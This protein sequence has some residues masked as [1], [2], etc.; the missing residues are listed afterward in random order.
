[1]T[2]G[3]RFLQNGA[4][5][6]CLLLSAA[7]YLLWGC[8]PTPQPPGQPHSGYGSPETYISDSYSAESVGDESDGSLAWYYIP[9]VLK[10]T[11]SAPVVIFLHGHTATDPGTYRGHIRHLLRQ[12]C[13]VIYPVFQLS[14]A[15]A[16]WNDLDQ[17][18]MLQRATASSAEALNA[19]GD[20]ADR[21]NVVVYGH[22]LGGLLALCWTKAGGN[23]AARIVTANANLDPSTGIPEQVIGLVTLIDYA[24]MVPATT[25]PVILL[26]GDAD[27][28]IAP[29][30]QQQEAYDL[31][32]QA[33]SKVLYM[34]QSDGHGLPGL[35]ADHGAAVQVPPA[36]TGAT[37]ED[38]LDFRFFYAA[39]DAALDGQDGLS[40]DPGDWSDGTPVKPV[41][42][43][44]PKVS[45]K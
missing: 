15:M 18:A 42:Q 21:D 19:L 39:L 20:R 34:A 25:A 45:G 1:M 5:S 28:Q 38:A 13:I 9:G 37:G 32:T 36:G 23:P 3:K 43:L 16:L 44:L 22:S 35:T 29:L 14:G 27:T 26:W 30:S 24:A 41:V 12:G 11:T 17:N 7:G 8:D 31:L 4:A 40:F 33:A 6:V 10:N 2:T